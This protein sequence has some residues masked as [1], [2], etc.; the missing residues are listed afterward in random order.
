[1]SRS[2]RF[3]FAMMSLCS[4]PLWCQVEPSATG[5]SGAGSDDSY[6]TM[7]PPVSGSFYRSILGAHRE[8][9]LS[10]GVGT[11][12][13]YSDN[14]LVSAS[15][16][17]VSG[18]SYTIYPTVALQ[19]ST[20]RTNGGLQYSAGF[21]FYDPQSELNQVTQNLTAD[22]Q[23]KLSPRTTL[24]G[25]DTFTQNSSGFSQP[26]TLSGT[27]IS[28]SSEPV[29]TI[30]IFPYTSQITDNT[31]VNLGY[32]FS[33]NSMIGGGG[34]FSLFRFT[35]GT[36]DTGLFDSES[37]GGSGFYTR[38]MGRAQY[39][40]VKYGYSRST[41]DTYS[42]TAESQNSALFY[43]LSL[44]HAFS[45]S[46][47]GGASYV[48]ITS[49]GYPTS[50]TW[51]PSGSAS[52]GWQGRRTSLSAAYARAVSTGW[53]FIGAYISDTFGV[54]LGQ[55]LGR[56]LTASIGGNYADVQNLAAFATSSTQ[57]GHSLFGRASL[58]YSL[59]EHMTAA[60]DYS[61]VHQNYGGIAEIAI[62]P[63]ADRVA[64]SVNYHFR[65]PLGK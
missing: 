44:G 48:T 31:G 25:Q 49:P 61:R 55:Q 14:V 37:Y 53:G 65:R 60:A 17:P 6:M 9:Y 63:N 58:A 21:I 20:G 41:S 27:T 24:N 28:G 29:S 50:N 59:T 42:T 26:D 19:T 4:I 47:S 57:Q 22:F 56:K 38:R 30:V 43:S 45:L 2:I 34:S 39:I 46:V 1:M 18:E 8:N 23:Y 12:A 40:G 36:Q 32:Q 7:P 5:G 33:R 54:S 15:G 62:D 64:V 35:N 3:V 13:A 11:S 52:F 10:G 16:R 51:A